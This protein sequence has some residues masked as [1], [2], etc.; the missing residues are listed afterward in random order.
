MPISPEVM[1]AFLVL[2]LVGMA[3]VAALYL[4]KR[5]LPYSEYLRWGLLILFLPYLGPFLVILMQPGRPR[6]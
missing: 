2:S 4:R 3:V 1:R 5:D 6:K